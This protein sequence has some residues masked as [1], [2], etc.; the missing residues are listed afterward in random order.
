MIGVRFDVLSLQ[1]SGVLLQPSH[2]WIVRRGLRSEPAW[3]R[4]RVSPRIAPSAT[5]AV[6]VGKS[7]IPLSGVVTRRVV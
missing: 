4:R 5:F 2:I 7:E 1:S 3:T 6:A